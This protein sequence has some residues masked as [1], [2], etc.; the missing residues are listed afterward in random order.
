[1]PQYAELSGAEIRDL[2][3]AGKEVTEE[4]RI[5]LVAYLGDSAP[6]GLDQ[7]PAMYEAKILIAEMTFVAP[8]HRKEAIHKYGHMH[9]NDFIERRDR[10]QNERIIAG[11]FSTRYH[12]K[13]VLAFVEKGL[14]GLLDGRLY[15]WL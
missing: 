13:Q 12:D 11:H 5:P 9:L 14:P 1:M 6:A 15:L 8:D 10:F 4:R 2:R 3:V 7:C